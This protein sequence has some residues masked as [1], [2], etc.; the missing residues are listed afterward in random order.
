MAN[1]KIVISKIG[2]AA[3]FATL[4]SYFNRP[5]AGRHCHCWLCGSC[6]RIGDHFHQC[7]ECDYRYCDGCRSS[8]FADEADCDFGIFSAEE[9]AIG[10]ADDWDCG[11]WTSPPDFWPR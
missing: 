3:A 6:V 2:G 10:R 7:A 9:E 5:L 8:G 1:A 4:K 11:E